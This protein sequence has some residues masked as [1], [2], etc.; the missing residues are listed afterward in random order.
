[1]STWFSVDWQQLFVPSQ[2]V[3]ETII[4]GSATYL[5]LFVLLRL[6]RRQTGSLGPADLLVLLLIADASQNA[7]AGEYQA[8]TDGLILVATIVAW[9]YVL[10]WLSFYVPQFGK[11]IDRQPLKVVEDGKVIHDHLRRELMT[12]DE[13]LSQMRQKGID[14]FAAVKRSFIEGDGSISVI[15][16][17]ATSSSQMQQ[18]SADSGVP[19]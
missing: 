10:D 17:R 2:P 1:M 3:L 9:E 19:A 8:I 12:E 11:L 16:D 5:S 6:F 18:G 13:L 14:G 7:M 15:T 4:R